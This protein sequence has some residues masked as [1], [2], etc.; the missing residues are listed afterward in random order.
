[1]RQPWWEWGMWM[2]R[3]SVA[4]ANAA[5][6]AIVVDFVP[7]AGV[8][9]VLL[10]LRANNDGD[11]NGLQILK[12]DEDDN[13]DVFYASVSSGATTQ[14]TVPQALSGS[15]S[16]QVV[17]DSTD[18]MTRFF[19]ADDKLTVNQTGAGAQNDT[20]VISLR[21]FLSCAERPIVTKGRSTN[22]S[23]VTIGTPSLDK[24]R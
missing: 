11:A 13:T 1:M 15:A 12:T 18:P 14:A 3:V 7:V 8:S 2:Y 22:P 23:D 6:G 20:L 5:G 9:M 16:D 21:A 17:I 10:H 19:R 4:Q 24:I